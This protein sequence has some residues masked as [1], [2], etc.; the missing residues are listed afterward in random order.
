MLLSNEIAV[1]RPTFIGNLA[2]PKEPLFLDAG[3]PAV[4]ADR[5]R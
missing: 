2:H 1:R 3:P 5:W 4:D